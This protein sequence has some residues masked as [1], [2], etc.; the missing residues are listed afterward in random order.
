MPRSPPPAA[1]E[2]DS[3]NTKMYGGVDEKTLEGQ[4]KQMF[5]DLNC[6]I[7]TGEWTAEQNNKFIN[8]HWNQEFVHQWGNMITAGYSIASLANQQLQLALLTRDDIKKLISG[9]DAIAWAIKN[10]SEMVK[11]PIQRRR[12]TRI[13]QQKRQRQRQGQR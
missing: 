6:G 11:A 5:L 12:S 3:T 8:E 1:A 7:A 10:L 13:I 9:Q 2:P 4:I